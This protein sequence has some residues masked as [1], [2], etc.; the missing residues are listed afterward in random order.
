MFW[1]PNNSSTGSTS[2]RNIACI[3]MMEVLYERNFLRVVAVC[4]SRPTPLRQLI[5]TG[6]W[7]KL[8]WL[9]M[10]NVVTTSYGEK[11]RHIYLDEPK[12]CAK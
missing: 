2:V 5:A 10:G 9:R 11:I 1:R 3:M 7:R 6:I 4:K 8:E 12:Y